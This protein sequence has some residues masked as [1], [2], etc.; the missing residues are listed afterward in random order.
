MAIKRLS[1]TITFILGFWSSAFSGQGY[2]IQVSVPDLPEQPVILSHRFGMKFYTDD[3]VRTDKSGSAVFEGKTTLPRGMYQL[4]FPD[5]KFAEF[6]LDKDQVFSLSTKAANPEATLRFRGSDE[7]TKFVEWQQEYTANRSRSSRIQERLKKGNL[8]ADSSAILKVALQKIQEENNQ[9]WDTA[10]KEL[11]GTLPGKF[12]RGLKPVIIPASMGKP[13]TPENQMAQYEYVRYHF[14]DGVDFS[15]DGLLRT[16]LIETKL[17]QYFRQIAPPMPDTLIRDAERIIELARPVKDMYQFVVQYLFNLY[18]DPQI[19]GTDA[20]YVFIARKY[21]L[22]GQTPW[23]DSANLN[24]IRYRVGE[25][26]PLLLGK[27]A[28]KLEGLLDRNDKPLDIGQIRSKY[29]I[30]YFWSPECGFC[31]EAT[32]K[33]VKLYPELKKM[34]VEVLAINTRLDKGEWMKFIDEHQLDW[35]NV[36]CPQTVKEIMEKYQAF[37]TPTIY[38]LDSQRRIIGKNI[39]WEQVMPFFKQYLPKN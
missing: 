18:S 36:Y 1:I 26:E 15:D 34:D 3:T 28:P 11:D 8:P 19:M 16:P 31:K 2:R 35:M 29:L 10:I 9:L 14:F 7:N 5:K 24:G 17:D 22:S 25:I 12:I 38:I 20:V 33:F 30:L 6:F 39:S 13:G 4:V 21:Y 23:I 37:S 32:P 27:Q